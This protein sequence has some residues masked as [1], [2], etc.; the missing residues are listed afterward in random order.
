MIFM[1]NVGKHTIVP[2]MRAMGYVSC[3]WF[4]DVWSTFYEHVSMMTPWQSL[5]L[6]YTAGCIYIYVQSMRMHGTGDSGT[7]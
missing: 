1:V 6:L 5:N 2:W 4:G 7:V 3:L